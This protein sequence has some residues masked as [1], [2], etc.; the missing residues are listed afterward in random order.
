MFDKTK[1]KFDTLLNDRINAPVRTSM[2]IACAAFVIAG[3]ALVIV[4]GNHG[5]R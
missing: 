4:V 5:K 2:I 3:V 1:E